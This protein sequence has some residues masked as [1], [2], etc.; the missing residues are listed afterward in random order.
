MSADPLAHRPGI[1]VYVE[2]WLALV[3]RRPWVVLAVV[4]L[5]AAASLAIA[6]RQLGVNTDPADLL[7]RDLPFQ[8]VRARVGAAFP[9]MDNTL[10]LV[11]EAPA[12]EQARATAEQLSERLG[13]MPEVFSAVD[14]PAGDRFLRDNGLLLRPSADLDRLADQLGQAQPMLARLARSP[15]VPGLLGLLGEVA[16]NRDAIELDLDPVFDSIAD[17]IEASL[18]GHDRPLSWQRLLTPAET[19]AD[20]AGPAREVLLVRPVLDFGKVMAGRDAVLAARALREDMGLSDGPVRMRITGSV[21]LA[22]EELQSVIAGASLA[23]LLALIFVTVMMYVGLRSLRLV[24]VALLS[25]AVGL[26][27]TLGFATLAIGHL[28]LISVAFMVLYVGLGVNYAIHLLLRYREGLVRGFVREDAVVYSGTHLLGALALSAATTA[29]GFFAFVP[30]SYAG[31]AELGLIA[32]V[33]M[34]ITFAISYTLVP[35]ML[36]L[37]PPPD[38]VQRDTVAVLPVWLLDIPLR[39]LVA[40]RWVAVA[41]AVIGLIAASQLRFDSDPLNLRDPESESVVALRDLLAGRATGHRNLQAIAPDRA[42]AQQM[43]SALGA[44][45]S[46][47][48]A[49]TLLNFAPKGQDDKLLQIEEMRWLLGPDIL[50]VEWAS[51]PAGVDAVSDAIAEL[52]PA[53]DDIDDAAGDGA[54]RLSAALAAL[55]DRLQS[56]SPADCDALAIG[57]HRQLLSLLPAALEPLGQA[58]SVD[59]PV[60]LDDLPAALRSRWLSPAGDWLIQI[61]PAGDL[62]EAD[63]RDRFLRDVRT[64]APAVSGMPVIQLESGRAITSAF[65]QALAL[66]LIGI[67]LLLLVLLRSVKMTVW[68]MLPLLLGGLLTAAAMVSLDMAF[69]FANVIALPLL[70]GV[71]VDNGVHLVYRHRAGDLPGGNV[72]RSATARGIVFGALTTIVSFGNLAFSPHAGTASMGLVLAVGLALMVLATLIVLPALLRRA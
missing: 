61:F 29:I 7:D 25:L 30:T 26:S 19:A 22:Y 17:G 42:S 15:T 35:A 49:V 36:S 8:D 37:I 13:E 50:A 51:Q 52:R 2:R 27:I 60:A 46:V 65:Q 47:D 67:A 68:I 12:P 39:H 69:N 53:L 24:L 40:V 63:E 58:L 44:L 4:L 48:R 43:S 62:S 71:G 28:N 56:E 64:V 72:L 3:T 5:I 6:S 16:D 1:P 18:A 34:G 55:D 21:A 59:R 38:N 14:W 41:L 45:A 9:L 57:L 10:L 11:V 23:G 32:G 33:A 66:A 31:V 54:E 70:L 20:S